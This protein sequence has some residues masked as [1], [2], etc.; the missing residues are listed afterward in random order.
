MYE[1]SRQ[2]WVREY[3]TLW[4]ASLL[5]AIPLGAVGPDDRIIPST[6]QQ[7]GIEYFPSALTRVAELC[8][9]QTWVRGFHYA[10]EG[11]VVIKPCEISGFLPYCSF[12]HSQL[13]QQK[14]IK[15]S[16]MTI[17]DMDEVSHR[18]MPK[19]FS[20]SHLLPAAF[21]PPRGPENPGHSSSCKRCA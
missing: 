10:S 12:R 11:V 14:R 17:K 7:H 16:A 5:R 4:P 19:V 20:G 3:G 13:W 2:K 15:L 1:P 8:R 9:H 18:S 21:D 6:N